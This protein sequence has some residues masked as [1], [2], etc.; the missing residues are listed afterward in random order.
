MTDIK[1]GDT[2]RHM[3]CLDVELYVMEV[4]YRGFSY[5]KLDVYYF[6]RVSKLCF[7]WGKPDLVTIKNEDFWKWQNT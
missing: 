1:R 3:S 6:H 4:T 2:I 5:V 7:N